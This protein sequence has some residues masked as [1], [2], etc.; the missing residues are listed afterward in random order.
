M[1]FILGLLVG[2]LIM[3]YIDNQEFKKKVND[4]FKDLLKGKNKSSK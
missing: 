2:G 3:H 1:S 4:W